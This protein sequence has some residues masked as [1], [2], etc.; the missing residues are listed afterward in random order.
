MLSL[1]VGCNSLKDNVKEITASSGNKTIPVFSNG[2]DFKT[3][4]KSLSLEELV[5]IKNKERV[6]IKFNEKSPKNIQLTEHILNKNGTPKFASEKTGKIIKTKL[7]KNKTSFKV[8][9]NLATSLSSNGNDFNPGATIKG[10]HLVCD[11]GNNQ[12]DYYFVIRGDAAI[13]NK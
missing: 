1:F 3:I 6:L 9:P 11:W 12:S 2:E 10:Y 4:M 7:D 13:S 5:Y 8:E